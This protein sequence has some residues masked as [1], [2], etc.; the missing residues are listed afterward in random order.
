MTNNDKYLVKTILDYLLYLKEKWD[1]QIDNNS[2]RIS[3]VILRRLLIEDNL[4]RAW[5]VLGLLKQ[6]KILAPNLEEAIQHIS[7]NKITFAQAGGANFKG[8]TINYLCEV[9]FAMTPEQIKSRSQNRLN[10][11]LTPFYL[12][13]FLE[14]P[15]FI[16]EG[17]VINRRQ[18]I[19]YITN[20]LGG[21]HIDADRDSDE[22]EFE[23]LDA[24][25]NSCRVIDKDAIYYELLSL[26]QSLLRSR[27][28]AKFIKLATG[29][30][31][32]VD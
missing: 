29:C 24:I 30:L 25:S 10:L 32:R 21:V 15:C 9:N 20:K 12:N 28:I 17:N 26:G 5:R 18:L 6:P 7:C 3:S 16:Y 23:F 11:S 14:S 27:D 2:L 31:K 1:Q 13:K 4:G 19:Q 8:M 22:Q